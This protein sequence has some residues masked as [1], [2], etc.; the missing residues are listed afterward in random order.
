MCLGT[1]IFF[2]NSDF[3]FLQKGSYLRIVFCLPSADRPTRTPQEQCTAEKWENRKLRLFKL[4]NRLFSLVIVLPI[5]R[6]TLPQCC[7]HIH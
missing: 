2:C 6:Q 5:S 3:V 7:L 1:C 4:H